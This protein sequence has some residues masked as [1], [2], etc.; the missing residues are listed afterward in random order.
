MTPTAN[1]LTALVLA[2]SRGR[3]DPVARG[4][5]RRHKA[6]VPVHRVPMLERVIA[7]LDASRSIGRLALSLGDTEI[8]EELPAI[9]ARTRDGGIVVVPAASSPA[10]SVRAALTGLDRPYP[11]L[12][13]T[14]DHPLLT[15]EM[16]DHF[17]TAAATAAADLV[18]AVATASVV[19]RA[20]PGA[21]R[22]Y[23]RFAGEGYSGCNLFYLRGPAAERAVAFWSNM[24][25]HRKRPWRLI[26]A[27]G[28]WLLLRFVFG[29]LT[30]HQAVAALSRRMGVSVTA[31]PLPFAEAAID[32]DKLSDLALAEQILQR[33]ESR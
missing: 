7:A 24:E 6:L 26:A 10:E 12:V 28:P 4:A 15:A 11:L 27:I 9:A 2:G 31:L 32:V 1:A 8:I 33:R 21:A 3:S 14:S 30:L 25:R 19:A 23:Y 5:G 13:T 17:C 22:T 18:V 20:Y 29:R 16:I